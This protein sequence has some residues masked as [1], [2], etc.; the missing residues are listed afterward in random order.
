[1]VCH[2]YPQEGRTPAEV[3]CKEVVS[4][5]KVVQK[6][7]KDLESMVSKMFRVCIVFILL[8]QDLVTLS[9]EGQ[10]DAVKA[11]LESG[12]NIDVDMPDPKVS[13]YPHI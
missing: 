2:A 13:F 8:K 10:L 4:S 12:E 7:A 6:E 11:F 9:K 1:M 5:A 3:G